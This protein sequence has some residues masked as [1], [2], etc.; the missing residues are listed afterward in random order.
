[1]NEGKRSE[2]DSRREP[3]KIV[4]MIEVHCPG[5]HVMKVPAEFAAD[6]RTFY[7]RECAGVFTPGTNTVDIAVKEITVG[8]PRG[9][10]R[11][12]R[13]K[14]LKRRLASRKP[15]VLDSRAKAG[16]AA[17]A[18]SPAR[19]GLLKIAEGCCLLARASWL[20]TRKLLSGSGG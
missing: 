11:L 8:M 14:D 7:C 10:L 3:K 18:S 1:M 13:W 9:K 16:A 17:A 4:P 6:G 2:R 19:Q 15:G 20:Q 5:G 12:P